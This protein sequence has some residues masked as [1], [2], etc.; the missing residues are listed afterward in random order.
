MTDTARSE[1]ARDE[2]P[3]PLV[4]VAFP[5]P[6][7]ASAAPASSLAG[8]ALVTLDRPDALNALSFDLLDQLVDALETLD[9]DPAC[10]AI[11]ITGSGTRAFAA[12]ADIRELEPQTSAS[13]TA[14]GRFGDVGP[15]GD[16][17]SAAHRRRPGRRPRWRL[18]AGDDL[19]HDRRRRGRELRPAR[20]PDRGHAGRRRHAAADPGDRQGARDGAHPDRPVDERDRGARARPRH[21]GRPARGDG[22]CGARAGGARSRRCRRSRSVP[23]RPPSSMPATD[24]STMAWPGSAPRSS[25]CSTPTTRRRGWPP[26]PR[27][28]RPS[29]RDTDPERAREE[30]A[31][32]ARPTGRDA[33]SGSTSS[34]T[35]ATNRPRRSATARPTTSRPIDASAPVSGH[36]PA[37]EPTSS[38]ADA[39]EQDWGHAQGLLYPAF[40][41]VGTQGLAMDIDRPARSSPRTPPRATP[42]RSSTRARPAC[43]SSTRST[44]GRTTSSS[45]ATTCWPGASSRP[46]SRTPPCATWRPG[47]RRRPGPTRCPA[48]AASSAPTPATAGTPRGSCCP[49]S[50]TTS[51]AELGSVGRIL[52]GLPERHLLTAASLRPDDPDFAA[53]FADFIVEQSGG[54]GRADRPPRLRARGRAA[55]RV[56]RRLTGADARRSDRGRRGGHS[57]RSL[58]RTRSPTGSRRS[59]S[60]GP[61]RSTR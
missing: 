34:A 49:R 41:P 36:S 20:D 26:S 47:R 4:R 46:R 31:D 48:S 60:T 59:R 58:V 19:R 54:G 2:R 24:R 53:L 51:C 7:P 56:R 45:T 38:P 29:G 32:G 40:R 14:G 50:S 39:P 9:R 33:T 61:T 1:A 8:V 43:R 21:P 42:S 12:G 3:T 35:S 28:A 30:T 22:R 17:R 13:L 16:G 10:R 25:A 6:A 44:P 18:R 15:A 55:R 11:V 52:I 23:P 5:A 37:P 57:A 27:S